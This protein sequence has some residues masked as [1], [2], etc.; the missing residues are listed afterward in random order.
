VDYIKTRR[1]MARM[2]RA[3]RAIRLSGRLAL[4]YAVTDAWFRWRNRQGI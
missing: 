2:K 4:S 3:V 1:L